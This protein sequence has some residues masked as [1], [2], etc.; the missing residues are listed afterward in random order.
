MRMACRCPP[1]ERDREPV[2]L[3][4]G[5]EPLAP[6]RVLGSEAVV[7]EA[8]GPLAPR[9]QP[10]RLQKPSRPA[11]LRQLPWLPWQTSAFPKDR[12]VRATAVPSR[13]GAGGPQ[14]S[15]VRRLRFAGADP[16]VRFAWRLL[17]PA[18]L[19]SETHL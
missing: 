1:A 18:W 13:S 5:W 19:T 10:P 14:W 16:P 7:Q 6:E 2:S 3:P 12:P 4:G 8:L 15:A 17:E 11:V 9:R